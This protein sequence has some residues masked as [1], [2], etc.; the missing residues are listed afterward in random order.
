MGQMVKVNNVEFRTRA[1]IYSVGPRYDSG[2][3]VMLGD[4]GGDALQFAVLENG[5][6]SLAGF[7]VHFDTHG[8]LTCFLMIRSFRWRRRRRSNPSTTG[9]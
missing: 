7:F 1:I 2:K 8:K 5:S 9:F 6:V 3:W 4:Y